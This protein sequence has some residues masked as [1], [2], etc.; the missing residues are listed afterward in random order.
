LPADVGPGE[1]LTDLAA[2]VRAPASAGTY[3]LQYDLLH[4]GITWF[5]WQG[6]ALRQVTVTV[7]NS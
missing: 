2:S 4:E 1:V 6:A 7:T 5:S 3:C